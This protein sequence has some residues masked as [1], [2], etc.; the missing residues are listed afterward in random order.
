MEARSK[1]FTLSD[2]EKSIHSHDALQPSMMVGQ[3]QEVGAELEDASIETDIQVKYYLEYKKIYFTAFK[4]TSEIRKQ[5][6]LKDTLAQ[7]LTNIEV[8]ITIL[9]LS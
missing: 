4:L 2:E 9:R 7:R 3:L 8:F 1:D 6:K 5:I